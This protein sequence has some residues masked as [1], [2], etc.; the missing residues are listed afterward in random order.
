MK[1]INFQLRR[2]LISI[3][4]VGALS[5]VGVCVLV[6]IGQRRMLY[7]PTKLTEGAALERAK[8]A[9]LEPW[10]DP[11]G[12]I[13]G[14]KRPAPRA[15]ARLVVFHGN[16]GCAADRRF[17]ADAFGA[18]DGGAAW[19]VSIFEYPGY[20]ARDGSPSK[21]A[22]ITAGRSAV[23]GLLAADN[24]PLFLFGESIGSGTAAALA[25]V[26]SGKIAGVV[27]MIPF[28][29]LQDVAQASFPWLPV[30]L[31]LRDKFDNLAA[32]AN[33]RAPAVFII[34]ENDEV[35]GAAQGR[36]LYD[37]YAGRKK[38][39]VLPGATHNEFP[40]APEERW[41]REVDS[42]LRE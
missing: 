21:D 27:M 23:E 35:V 5:Y 32:L 8:G 17:Y 4:R 29:R 42:F 6:A 13:I 38:L 7:F 33:C 22:F 39:I 24:R 15:A 28:A 2:S 26:L 19:E 18:I 30:A 14:W 20:G 9:Q 40:S 37:A 41:F 1:P 3:F 11:H 16:G 10:R 25:G 31:L 34:A 12:A 36:Q